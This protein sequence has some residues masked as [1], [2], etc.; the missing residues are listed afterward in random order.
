MGLLSEIQDAAVDGGLE[1]DS[2]LHVR[3]TLNGGWKL[4]RVAFE[5]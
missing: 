2:R 4:R 3:P 1:P 5:K